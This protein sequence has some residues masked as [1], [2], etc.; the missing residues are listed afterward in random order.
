MGRGGGPIGAIFRGV[1]SVVGGIGKTIMGGLGVGKKKKQKPAPSAQDAQT[2][3][4][5]AAAAL[6][7]RQRTLGYSGQTSTILGG[8]QGVTEEANTSR[9]T[10]G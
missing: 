8:T 3:A 7:M 4:N 10:L 9:A 6:G 5:T 2:S 1:K